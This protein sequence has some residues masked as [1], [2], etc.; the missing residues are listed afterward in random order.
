MNKK[1]K[2][3]KLVITDIKQLNVILKKSTKEILE[4]V[5]A[6]LNYLEENTKADPNCHLAQN[7]F[8]LTREELIKRGMKISDAEKSL[9]A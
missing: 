6:D 7:I 5:N 4:I 3:H 9:C 2:E 8:T 1:S